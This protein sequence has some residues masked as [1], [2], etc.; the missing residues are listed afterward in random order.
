LVF[1]PEVSGGWTEWCDP[2]GKARVVGGECYVEQCSGWKV[3]EPDAAGAWV[4]SV[5]QLTEDRG[6]G[7]RLDP[8]GPSPCR[9]R[10]AGSGSV[11]SFRRCEK[12]PLRLH[13]VGVQRGSASAIRFRLQSGAA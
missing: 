11:L 12:G 6:A 3:I 2:G 5:K 9:C 8:T 1:L 13:G 10:P 7:V 4:G